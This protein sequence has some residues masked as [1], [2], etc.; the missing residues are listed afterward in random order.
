M[1]PERGRREALTVLSARHGVV[2]LASVWDRV[3]AVKGD[4]LEI[5]A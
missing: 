2:T 4:L 5:Q 3:G 1:F